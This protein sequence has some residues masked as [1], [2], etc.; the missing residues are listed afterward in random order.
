MKV[1]TEID[2]SERS[3]TDLSAESKLV[4][5]SGLH[6]SENSRSSNPDRPESGKWEKQSTAEMWGGQR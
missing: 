2:L 6:S 5:N 4:S 1:Q 3:T